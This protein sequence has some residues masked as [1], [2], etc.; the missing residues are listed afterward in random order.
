MCFVCCDVD[1][2]LLNLYLAMQKVMLSDG[3]FFKPEGIKT[4]KLDGKFGCSKREFYH[5]LH[6]MRVYDNL[7]FY[8][9]A[10]KAL[11]K[12]VNSSYTVE[13]Y[14]A[15]VK[16]ENIARRRY[17]FCVNNGMVGDVYIRCKPVVMGAE[18]VFEDNLAVLNDWY[19]GGYE[20]QMYLIDRMHNQRENNPEYDN[21]FW[22]AIV[23]CRDFKDAVDRFLGE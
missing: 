14:T 21:G 2:V 7:I 10:K 15:T 19:K 4:F 22:D 12:L 13:M 8:D 9:G 3:I 17:E 20:G 18:A 5:Y 23:R 1:G 6:D 11:Q 16:D